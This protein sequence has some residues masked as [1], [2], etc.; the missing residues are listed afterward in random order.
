M[1]KEHLGFYKPASL[2]FGVMRENIDKVELCM[3]M[4]VCVV[5]HNMIIKDE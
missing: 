2:S 3:I 5:L 4:K 1:W